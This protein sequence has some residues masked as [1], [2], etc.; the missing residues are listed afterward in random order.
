MAIYRALFK[1]FTQEKDRLHRKL[2]FMQSFKGSNATKT[3]SINKI[4]YYCS[5]QVA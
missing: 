2:E 3:K 4:R 5:V 1:L